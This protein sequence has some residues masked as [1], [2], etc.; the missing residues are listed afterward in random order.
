MNKKQRIAEENEVLLNLWHQSQAGDSLAFCQLADKQYRILFNYACNFTSDREFIKDAIQDLMIHIW[1]RRQSIQI[2]FVTIYFL[3]AL[4]NQLMQEF[5]RNNGSHPFLDID[6]A[7]QLS[8]YQTV[9][10]EIERKELLSENQVKVRCAIEELPRRQKE[11]VFLKYFEG[12]D[13]EQIADLMQVNRQSVANLLF[14]AISALKQHI[15]PISNLLL[16][17]FALKF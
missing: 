13:N 6:E 12:M 1:E 2:Q 4:R 14:K 8:D 10:T 17:C 3:R 11:A 5:R 15:H 16:L 9:E 7:G